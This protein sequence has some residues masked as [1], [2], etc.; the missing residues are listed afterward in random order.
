[1]PT[2]AAANQPYIHSSSQWGASILSSP[3]AIPISSP[4]NNKVAGTAI[5]HLATRV[6]Q[7]V[8]LRGSFWLQRG[9]ISLAA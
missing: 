3:A 4:V 6:C 5:T 1:M 2:T 8:I 9:P 7:R